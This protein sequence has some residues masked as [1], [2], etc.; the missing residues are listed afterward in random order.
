MQTSVNK[1]EAKKQN[2]HLKNEGESFFSE[3]MGSMEEARD[4]ARGQKRS[5]TRVTKQHFEP[6]TIPTA[7]EI[8]NVRNRLNRTQVVFSEMLGVVI[9]LGNPTK[10]K[11]TRRFEALLRT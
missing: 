8:R 10:Y 1:K 4:F 9:A 11:Q 6:V 2:K 7:N 3:L 5:G